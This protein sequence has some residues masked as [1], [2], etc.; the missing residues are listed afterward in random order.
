[1]R[2]NLGGPVG[3][4]IGNGSIPACAGEPP[5]CPTSALRP[6]VYPRVCGGTAFKAETPDN[7]KGLSPR[8]RGNQV[9]AM[10]R[11]VRERSIPAC[12]GE[13]RM[14]VARGCG[15]WVYPRVCGGTRQ[16]EADRKLTAGLSPR[17]RGNRH[18]AARARQQDGSIPACAGEPTSRAN[19]RRRR[20]VYPRVCGGTSVPSAYSTMIAGLSP[21]VRGN[22]LQIDRGDPALGS[23]PACAGEP[24]GVCISTWSKWVYPRVCGGTESD[25][26]LTSGI[27]GLS[28]RVR[29]NR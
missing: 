16:E 21:R 26:P 2:G 24:Q 11:E 25:T 3:G 7:L 8:V 10:S 22:R 19:P 12:A 27:Q 29:G 9:R 5:R 13:P 23:I 20:R 14:T 17:V 4:M 1:M 18:D 6:K 15:W 28:P